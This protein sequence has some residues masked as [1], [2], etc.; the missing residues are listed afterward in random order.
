MNRNSA[1]NY[2][3]VEITGLATLADNS[4]YVT[5]RGPSNSTTQ[6]AAP[7]NT[8]LEF[9]RVRVDGELTDKMENIRQIR[10]LNPTTPSLR[11]GVGLSS[12]VTFVSPRWINLRTKLTAPGTGYNTSGRVLVRAG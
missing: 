6:V 9:R 11:S 8:V 1:N 10:T 2:E 5:R 12:I 3:L 7:D 4:L